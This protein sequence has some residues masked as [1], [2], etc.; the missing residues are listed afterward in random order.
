MKRTLPVLLLGVALIASTQLRA[1]ITDPVKTDAGQLS[2]TVQEGV[3]VYKGVPFAAP[4]VG[5]LRW[6]EPQPVAKWTGVRKADTYGN[7][8]MQNSAKQR[9][10]PNSAI[11]L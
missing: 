9:F 2:G 11:D 5:A 6:K 10:P 3:R 1:A 4:P 8:C 7:A